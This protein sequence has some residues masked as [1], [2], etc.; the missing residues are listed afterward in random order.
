LFEKLRE[1][2][3]LSSEMLG[4]SRQEIR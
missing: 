3:D 1:M 4:R 2:A